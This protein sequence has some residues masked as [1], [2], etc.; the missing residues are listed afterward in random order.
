MYFLLPFLLFCLTLV[1]LGDQGWLWDKSSQGIST[2]D[3]FK[4]IIEAVNFTDLYNSKFLVMW[5]L[6][7]NVTYIKLI[8]VVSWQIGQIWW[9]NVKCSSTHHKP[10]WEWV[11]SASVCH[12]YFL[13]VILKYKKQRYNTIK[14]LNKNIEIISFNNTSDYNDDDNTNNNHDKTQL[15]G[16]RRKGAQKYGLKLSKPILK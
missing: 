15:L 12:K 11:P 6:L 5:F 7:K 2:V 1:K 3:F 4:E 16:A 8:K 10:D 13:L 14:L 9:Y